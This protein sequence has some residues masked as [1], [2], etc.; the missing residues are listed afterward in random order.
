V[1]ESRALEPRQSSEANPSLEG[2][3]ELREPIADSLEVSSEEIAVGPYSDDA[4]DEDDVVTL[5]MDA[6]LD[7]GEWMLQTSAHERRRLSTEQLSAERASGA[8]PLSTRVWRNGMRA[9]TPLGDVDLVSAE[10]VSA[11]RVPAED[12]PAQSAAPAGVATH[13]ASAR[14]GTAVA[15]VGS[16]KPA[17]EELAASST[18][19]LVP[20][21]AAPPKRPVPLPS[22]PPPRIVPPP[23]RPGLSAAPLSSP[24]AGLGSLG[25]ASGTRALGS[26]P[27]SALGFGAPRALGL[28][29]PP[30]RVEAPRSE[31]VSSALPAFDASPLAASSLN[32]RPLN[33]RPPLHA[34]PLQAQPSTRRVDTATSVALDVGPV[35][36]R[37]A[38]P[39]G[40]LVAQG[41]AVVVALVGTSYALTRAGVFEPGA[42]GAAA[43]REVPASAR[44]ALQPASAP[45]VA[46]AATV[47]APPAP[48][49]EQGAASTARVSIPASDPSAAAAA[50]S[51]ASISPPTP[52]NAAAT[53]AAMPAAASERAAAPAAE[54]SPSGSTAETPSVSK[55][56]KET[57]EKASDASDSTQKPAAETG[58]A[59]EGAAAADPGSRRAK[60]A[61]R[62]AAALEARRQRRAA[63]AVAV[64]PRAEPERSEAVSPAQEPGSTFDRQAAQAALT[65]A[66][67]QVK[68]CRPIGGPSGAGTV[69]VQYEPSGRVASV[70]IVTPGFENSDAAGCI[71]M[72]FRRARVPAFNGA[73]GAEMRQRFEIP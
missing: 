63:R 43:H 51:S 37:R 38:R 25:A 66:S 15:N 18:R 49:A 3:P 31:P 67:E 40:G 12:I 35:A 29:P 48:A 6:P 59:D 50:P 30:P 20:P 45:A 42:S 72:L 23:S 4:D 5:Q 10:R 34:Q 61:A 68:N 24:V 28:S 32:D 1:K 22:P 27:S 57:S 60:R 8:L 62:R 54:S 33:D 26:S 36:S 11:E 17:L 52:S 13:G 53:S 46:P 9:W 69:Q 19:P 39:W 56:S 47:A 71:Q 2:S 21:L 14:K 41:A 65:A 70:T 73:K 64:P 58:T 55:E 16:E 44:L 7:D